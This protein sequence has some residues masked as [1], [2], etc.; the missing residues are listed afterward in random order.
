MTDLAIYGAAFARAVAAAG[1]NAPAVLCHDD[2]DGLS[3]GA[4]LARAVARRTGG[5]N[6]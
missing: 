5:D 1:P 3:A 6:R 2:A 4:I